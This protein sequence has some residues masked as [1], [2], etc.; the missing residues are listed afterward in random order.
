M[1]SSGRPVKVVGMSWVVQGDMFMYTVK[2]RK[3]EDWYWVNGE[4][5]IADMLTRGE[6]TG[7]LNFD[8]E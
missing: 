1:D 8:N 7:K 6:S 2:I 3:P 5:N 4:N